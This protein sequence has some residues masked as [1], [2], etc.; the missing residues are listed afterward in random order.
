MTAVVTD[1]SIEE[2]V[3]KYMSGITVRMEEVE[4]KLQTKANITDLEA[5]AIKIDK[6]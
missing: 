2:T 5:M 4:G 1:R 3:K 6:N